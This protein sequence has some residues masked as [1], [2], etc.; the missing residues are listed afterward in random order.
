M[1]I[2]LGTTNSAIA[3]SVAGRFRVVPSG[4]DCQLP[5]VIYVSRDGSL[6]RKTGDARYRLV[7]SENGAAEF[8][9]MMG[10]NTSTVFPATAKK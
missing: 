4:G 6:I 7:D 9:R 2:D 5:S 8:K 10:S 3:V 1:Q